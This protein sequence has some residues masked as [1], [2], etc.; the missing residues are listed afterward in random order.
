MSLLRSPLFAPRTPEAPVRRVALL[1]MH[2]SPLAQPGTG[3]GG[4][5]NV[6]VLEV[7]RWLARRGVA[8]DVFTRADA[9]DRPPAVTVEEGLVVH[10]V[11]AGPLEPLDKGEL[12]AHVSAFALGVLGT[13]GHHDLVH[14]HYWLS[15]SAGRS[16][17]ARS[18]VPLVQTF[19]TLGVVKN[20]A[21]APGV[22]P[23]PLL[24]LAAER[25]LAST[26]D[27]LVVLT[28]GEART[29]H[30]TF[31]TSGAR[32][33]VVPGGVDPDVFN[34]RVDPAPARE[35]TRFGPEP[36][37][38][39]LLFVGRLQP[40]KGPD[41]AVRTLARV[42]RHVPARLLVVG[43]P[44]GAGGRRAGP[45]DLMR[46]A[47]DLGVGGAVRVAGARPQPALARLYRAADCVLVP[48]RSES[49]GLVALEAQACGTP[50]VAARVGG[51]SV[52]V[53]TGGVLVDGHEPADHARAVL[54]L[55]TDAAL[56]AR[57]GQAGA[58]QALATTWDD[59][60][61]R[62]LG[63]YGDVVAARQDARRPA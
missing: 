42:R 26:A 51:L 43:G 63:V 15:G 3:D 40:L 19:H 14:A 58:R 52:A 18:G 31:G 6:Y 23:E 20:G 7:G 29:L 41:L 49:F 30:R 54:P 12:R 39:L 61:D 62:L 46:L 50:V 53:G 57:V 35:V 55:L 45:G 2:T 56:R 28:C 37:G 21:R 22:P 32:I 48:S 11:R 27:R 38:P 47:A 34:P 5:L 25:R 33:A 17:A 59:T 36:D 4:G 60:A 16:I 44:S 13:A 8:V 24:R 1:S 9:P 10:H